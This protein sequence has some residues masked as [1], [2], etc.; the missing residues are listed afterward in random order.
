METV[1]GI[2]NSLLTIRGPALGVRYE[3][4]F[5]TNVD[6]VTRSNKK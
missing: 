5:L 1:M 6:V 4:E 2:A 3:P